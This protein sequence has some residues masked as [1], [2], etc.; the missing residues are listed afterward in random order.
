MIMPIDPFSWFRKALSKQDK[1]TFDHIME[2]ASKHDGGKVKIFRM[3]EFELHSID[4]ANAIILTI[5]LEH[6]KEII[7]LRARLKGSKSVSQND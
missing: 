2:R 5:M 1:E 6:E 7:E 4:P 3:G